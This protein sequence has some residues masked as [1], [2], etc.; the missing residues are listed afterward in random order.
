LPRGTHRAAFVVVSPSHD[1]QERTFE[2]S[3]QAVELC[4]HMWNTHGV[5]RL[6]AT[7]F[8]KSATSVGA[9]MVEADGAQTKPDFITKV[10]VAKKE[11]KE[12]VYW[13]RLIAATDATLQSRVSPL[14]SEAKQIAAIVSAIQIKAQ[15]NRT[16]GTLLVLL[17]SAFYHL[18]FIIYH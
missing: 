3:V 13:L 15:T 4:R 2:F 12:A 16:R 1:I 17:A 7:Q 11:A 14:L 9:N 8:L 18:A 5:T 10:S 6:L